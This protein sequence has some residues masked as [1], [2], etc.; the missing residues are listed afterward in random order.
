M[1]AAIGMCRGDWRQ[2]VSGI[3]VGQLGQR[4]DYSSTNFEVLVGWTNLIICMLLL[5]RDY[6]IKQ[7]RS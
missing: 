6:S 4:G 2:L 3:R 7:W 5:Y 1:M